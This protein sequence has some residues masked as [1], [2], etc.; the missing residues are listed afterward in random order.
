VDV[1][2]WDVSTVFAARLPYAPRPIFQSFSAYTPTLATRNAEHLRSRRAAE[3]VLFDIESIDGRLPAMDDGGSWAPLWARYTL[4]ADTGGFLWLRRRPTPLAEPAP[5]LLGTARTRL[6][7]PIPLPRV[8][9]G[10][11]WM[12]AD[13]RPTLA[14]RLATVLWKGPTVVMAEPTTGRSWR[15]IP[16]IVRSGFPV[17]PVVTRRRHF[18]ELM[19]SG[20]VTD[21]ASAAPSAVSLRVVDGSPSRYFAPDVDVR[22]YALEP[23]GVCDR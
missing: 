4:V 3:N 9:C 21:A 15:V 7:D 16:A 22:F 14:Y 8:A 6:G 5:R 12:Q 17:W 19:T 20:R 23:A 2:P 11:V 13:L 1:Y 10:A 18:A